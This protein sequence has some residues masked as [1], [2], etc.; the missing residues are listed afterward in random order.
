MNRIRWS[1]VIQAVALRSAIAPTRHQ[2]EIGASTSPPVIT[3]TRSA[4]EPMP[5]SPLSRSVSVLSLPEALTIEELR[6]T[7]DRSGKASFGSA[8]P[9]RPVARSIEQRFPKPRAQIDSWRVQPA[10]WPLSRHRRLEVCAVRLQNRLQA[11][12][13]VAWSASEK[14][15]FPAPLSVESTGIEPVT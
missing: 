5:T 11:D 13:R 6:A 8:K 7:A 14:C 10:A 9:K 3:T 12:V 4:R 2:I 15:L 1:A